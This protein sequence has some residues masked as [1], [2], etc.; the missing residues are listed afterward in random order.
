MTTASEMQAIPIDEILARKTLPVDIYILIA[1]SKY[2]LL[3][4]VGADVDV[5]KKF[6]ERSLDR[7]YVKIADYLH[8]V[9][10]AISEGAA[11][12][13]AVGA[14]NLVRIKGLQQALTSVYREIEDFGMDENAIKNAKLFNHSTISFLARN[15]GVSEMFSVL[16]TIAPNGVNHAMLVSLMASMIGIGHG[17]SK[18]ATIERLALG[19]LL[20]DIGKTRLP[21]DIMNKH[22]SAMT[23]AERTIYNGHAEIGSQMLLQVK[24]VPEDVVLMVKEHHEFVDGTGVPNGLKELF[25]SPLAKVIS[26]ADRVVEILED[27]DPRLRKSPSVILDIIENNHPGQFNKDAIAA[28]RRVLPR[29]NRIAG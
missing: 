26:L 10:L 14:T 24:S 1:G 18:P 29:A 11:T 7:F 12:S 19:G 4:K 23:E 8:L 9:Q 15:P 17:W 25:I 6:K 13:N 3:G 21:A 22:Y 27:S 28:L 20:H 5:L 16:D 2:L